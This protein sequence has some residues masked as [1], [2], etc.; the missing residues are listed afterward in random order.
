MHGLIEA[1]RVCISLFFFLVAS[2]SDYKT[3]EVSNRVWIVFAP[4]ALVL[5]FV[6]LFLFDFSAFALFGLCFGLTT[7]VALILFYVG[8]FGGA[9]AKALM[10]L[11]LALPFYPR[12]LLAPLSGE[13]SPFMRWFFPLAVFSNSVVLA[14]LSA[15]YLLLHN[16]FWLWKKGGVLFE[17]GQKDE[18]FGKKILV[19]ATGY[20]V[21]FAKVKERWYLYPMEDVERTENGLKRK[22]VVLPKDEGRNGI[23]KRLEEA[24][25]SGEI[26]EKVWAS[27]GL[28]MLIFLTA[29]LLIALFYGDMVWSLIRFLLG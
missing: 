26:G 22:L 28:P 12:M 19:L 13:V 24:A 18:S 23:I 1:A 20:K 8:G 4:P 11:A 3:R 7:A 17:G 21:S 27:P 15:V 5:T 2:W 29:G 25:I 9:D 16:F 14:A 10:C 6:E